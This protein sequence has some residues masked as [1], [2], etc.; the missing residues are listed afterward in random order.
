[1][2]TFQYPSVHPTVLATILGALTFAAAQAQMFV[3]AWNF[4]SAVPDGNTGTG[5]LSPHIGQ[6]S[7]SLLGGVNSSFATGAGSSDP[8]P[9][10]N[11]ALNLASF[12]PQGT[13]NGLRGLEFQVDT[14]GWGDISIQWD[15]RFS[16]TASRFAELQYSVNGTDFIPL[17]TYEYTGAANNWVNGWTANLS[18]I[19]GVSD[20]PAFAFRIV[21][22]FDPMLGDVYSPVSGSYSTAGTWRFDSV[23][24]SGMTLAPVP[25]PEEY[26]MMA[27]GGLLAFGWYR[28]RRQAGTGS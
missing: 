6:G 4:N 20:N 25:E 9:S 5:S 27:A 11:S 17:T 16:G 24:V 12:A 15:Q 19:D 22:V 2:R 1:M 3:A 23:N 13:Q 14:T 28:K 10:D 21:S 26:A 7:L 8:A 18:G